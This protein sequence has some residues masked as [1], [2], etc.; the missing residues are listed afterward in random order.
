V[1]KNHTVSRGSPPWLVVCYEVS[2]DVL[3][4]QR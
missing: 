4:L 3:N 2:A 1:Y